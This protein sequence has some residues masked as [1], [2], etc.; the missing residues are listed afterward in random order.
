MGEDYKFSYKD[1]LKE[2]IGLA[3]YNTGCQKCAGGYAWGPGQR[4]HYLV[5]YVTAGKGRLFC[6]GKTYDLKAGDLFFVCPFRLVTYAADE[7][8]PWEYIWVGFNG[9]EAKRLLHL[10]GLSEESPVHHAAGD[11]DIPRTLMDI[12][13]H[14]GNTPAADTEMVGRLY[15]FLSSLM[16]EREGNRISWTSRDYVEQALRF[17][18]RNYAGDLSVADI[19]DY[20]GVSRSQLYREFQKE[21]GLSPK[22]YIQQY[23]INEA[24]SLLTA[25]K[26]TV[27]ETAASVGYGDALYFSRAFRRLKGLSPCAYR[28]EAKQRLTGNPRKSTPSPE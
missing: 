15:L 6:G 1:T 3:V 17:I 5:H 24:C 19:A 10:T 11:G 20:A 13:T 2:N 12:Y 4:D 27:A 22:E 28:Q 23:R 9:T 14:R 26:L 25:G 21:L 18:Q 7:T 16:R 8:E